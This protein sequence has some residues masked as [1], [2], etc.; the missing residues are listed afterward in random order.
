[1]CIIL[2]YSSR[3]YS[4]LSLGTQH[5]T[6]NQ[7]DADL[8]LASTRHVQVTERICQRGKNIK[9]LVTDATNTSTQYTMLVMRPD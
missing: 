7:R 3:D 1:M 2:D 6:S 8:P 9:L 4:D 5:V